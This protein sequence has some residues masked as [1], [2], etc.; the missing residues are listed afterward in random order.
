MAS[1]EDAGARVHFGDDPMRTVR[2]RFTATI[3]LVALAVPAAAQTAWEA[4]VFR[5]AAQLHLQLRAL[6]E[7]ASR[8]LRT[9]QDVARQREAI[10][11]A[12][13]QAEANRQAQ[14][15]EIASWPEATEIV[16]RRLRLGRNGTFELQNGAGNVVITGGRGDD[17]RIDAT[18]RAR[19][20]LPSTARSLLP[21][22]EI[23]I[24]QRGGNVELRTDQPR[25]RGVWTSVD[26]TISVP[27][28]ANVVLGI[29]T[30]NV[31]V[32]NVTGELRADAADGDLSAA[33]VRRVRHLR[34]M[35]GD[36][37]VAD[38]E[39]DELSATTVQGDLVLRNLKGRVL[40][41]NTIDG[42]MRLIDVQMS[43]ARLQTMAGDIEYAGPL[44]RSGRYEF[45]THSGNIRLTPSGSNGFDLEAHSYAGDIR[46]DY[47]LKA[48]GDL[49]TAVRRGAE[50]TMRGTFGDAGAVLTA[51]SF[52]GDILIVRR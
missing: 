26:Y 18:K 1:D 38:A 49:A 52:S 51:R 7:D 34:T 30:G 9:A 47:M 3:A 32:T 37:E 6:P 16:S 11:R 39:A 31:R 27:S 45:V 14:Q 8:Q 46:S 28:G 29:G 10:E 15:R 12:R 35:R 5:Q 50:R 44:A 21:E 36:I 24:M 48:F 40:D 22:V 2:A 13:R 17:V 4:D 23:E 33:G 42:D 25:R 41:V 43:R 19:H 20:R